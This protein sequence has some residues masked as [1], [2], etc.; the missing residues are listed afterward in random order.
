VYLCSFEFSDAF[1]ITIKT[2]DTD[3]DTDI[4]LKLIIK[5]INSNQKITIKRDI[6]KLKMLNMLERISSEKG[7]YWRV[8]SLISQNSNNILIKFKIKSII[9]TIFSKISTYDC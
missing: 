1:W 2:N 6:E 7:G 8:V 5:I 4:K 3:N 9:L